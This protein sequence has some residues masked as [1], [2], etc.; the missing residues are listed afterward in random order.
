MDP[1]V[2]H[3]GRPYGGIGFICKPV[4]NASYKPVQCDNDR[5]SGI[6]II[7]FSIILAISFL[8]LS[9]VHYGKVKY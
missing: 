6:Q 1:E 9:I 5:I 7:S 8:T 2:D 3:M 4:P